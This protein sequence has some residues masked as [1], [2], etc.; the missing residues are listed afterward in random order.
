V[1]S[2]NPL[3]GEEV[4]KTINVPVDGLCRLLNALVGMQLLEK[5]GG[6]Y[7]VTDDSRTFLSKD[8][9]KDIGFLI[10]HHHNLSK[11]WSRLDEAISSGKPFRRNAK[12]LD[13]QS[14]ESFLKGMHTTASFNAPVIVEKIDL[15]GNRRLLDLGG[16]PGT[17]AIHFCKQYPRLEAVVFD[18]PTSRSIALENIEKHGCSDR[19]GFSAGDFNTDIFPGTYDVVWMSHILHSEGE[20]A[21][22]NII[23]KAASVLEPGGKIFIHEFI[24]NEDGTCPVFPALFSLNMLLHSEKGRSY[25][26]EQL[27]AVLADSGFGDIRRI[28]L[29]TPTDS[30]IIWGIK[31]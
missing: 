14:I 20:G 30:G 16:G 18:L 24:L 3:T 10:R 29:Q 22:R 11:T 7:S 4:A 17:Y 28:M 26:E 5:T 25:T 19:I 6:K 31:K 12:E 9:D 21:C 15:S 13:S 27:T 1:L 2:A 23:K 8:S